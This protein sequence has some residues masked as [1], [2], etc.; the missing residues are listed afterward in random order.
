M[1]PQCPAAFLLILLVVVHSI[2][3]GQEVVP[4]KVPIG[5]GVAL[6]YVERGEGDNDF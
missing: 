4:K 1:K 6:H 3:F 2:A 5:D